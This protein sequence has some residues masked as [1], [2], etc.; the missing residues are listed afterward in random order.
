MKLK[1][2]IIGAWIYS[3]ITNIIQDILGK[4]GCVDYVYNHWIDTSITMPLHII[5][6]VAIIILI[7]EDK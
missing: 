2:L 4:Q 3:T 1:Y 6:I 7:M 5:S